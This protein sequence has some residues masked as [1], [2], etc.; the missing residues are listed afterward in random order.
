MPLAAQ[1]G[2]LVISGRIERNQLMRWIDRQIGRQG[3]V[4]VV[5]DLTTSNTLVGQRIDAEFGVYSSALQ[6]LNEC[7]AIDMEQL[8]RARGDAICFPHGFAD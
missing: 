1:C 2:F 4:R 3:F 7:R 5:N 8:R 6:F